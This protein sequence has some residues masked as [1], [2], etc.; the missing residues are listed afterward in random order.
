MNDL[1]TES[2]GDQP[3]IDETK[4]YLQDLVGEDKKFK[5]PEDLAKGKFLADSYVKILERRL[6]EMRTDYLKVSEENKARAKLEELIDQMNNKTQQ[7]TSSEQPPA[8]EVPQTPSLDQ[9]ESLVSN[10]ISQVETQRKERENFNLI[11]NKLKE[12]YGND[13]QVYL[14]KQTEDLGLSKEF[15]NDMARKHPSAFIRTFGLDASRSNDS[16]QAPPRTNVGFT[17]KLPEK[18]TWSYYQKLKQTD[19][20]LYLDPKTA[21]QM[22]DDAIA[23]GEE[24]ADG[25][26]YRFNKQRK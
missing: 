18:R 20:K 1:F 8:K 3:Q 24:F 14:N 11:T 7:L 15:V 22:Q 4:N 21:V 5:T 10:K 6:D 23:L 17:P 12:L 16:F 26:F 9:I 2:M 19:P 13:Y 25:D